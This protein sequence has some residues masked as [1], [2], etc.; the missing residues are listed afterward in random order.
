MSLSWPHRD[1]LLPYTY[2]STRGVI[3]GHLVKIQF[4]LDPLSKSDDFTSAGQTSVWLQL[5][6]VGFWL[7]PLKLQEA[8]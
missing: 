1:R 2:I 5:E 8:K 3:H 6:A 7:S 4:L